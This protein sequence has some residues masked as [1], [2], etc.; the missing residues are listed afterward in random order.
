M[1]PRGITVFSTG[2]F[3]GFSFAGFSFAC[4]FALGVASSVVGAPS[5]SAAPQ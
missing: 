5:P 2:S 4:L 3:A 1:G